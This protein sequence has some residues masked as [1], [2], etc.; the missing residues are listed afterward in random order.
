L[1]YVINSLVL[2][3]ILALAVKRKIHVPNNDFH[4]F[5]L[6]L[7][8]DKFLG[9]FITKSCKNVLTSF[10]ISVCPHV[11]TPEWLNNVS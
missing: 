7:V 5:A 9:T 6:Y 3:L 4:L 10:S 8:F 11:T 1:D 2:F